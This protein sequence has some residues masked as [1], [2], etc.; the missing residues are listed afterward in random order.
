MSN[1]LETLLS[2]NLL[3]P[4]EAFSYHVM[5]GIK[6]LPNPFGKVRPRS[7]RLSIPAIQKLAMRIGLLG[8]GVL[9]LSQVVGFVFGVWF[10]SAAL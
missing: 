10:A 4:P 8:A 5:Q 9:G 7:S 6:P 3:E 2:Q 1:D